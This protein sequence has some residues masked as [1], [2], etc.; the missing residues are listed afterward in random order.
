MH[1]YYLDHLQELEAEAI[2]V[3]REVAAKFDRPAI[4]FSGGKDSIVVTHL[5]QKA[6]W[7]AK[8]PMPVIHIDTGHNFLEAL[9]YRDQLV[10]EIGETLIVRKVEDTIRS[11]SLSEPRGKF[12][13]RNALQP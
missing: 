8:I 11:K 10:A 4:L 13:S 6:F 2:F 3:L 7:P 5:A 1:K 12:A 9:E